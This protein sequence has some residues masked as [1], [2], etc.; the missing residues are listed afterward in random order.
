M[1]EGLVNYPVWHL[2]FPG[3]LLIAAVAI[4]HVFVSH[5]AIGG[6]AYLV[7]TE[8]SAYRRN[9]P[10]LL[11]YV[12]R[13]SKFFA[14]LTVVFGAVSGVGIWF[15]IGLVGPE[16]TSSLI[17]T[18]VWA[19]AIEWVFF[20]VE[21]AAALIYAYQWDRLDRRSHLIVGWI[22]FAAGW[23]S[24][25]VIAGIIG[26]MLTPGRW[27]Q[28]HNFWD[29][30]FNPSYWPSVG[31]RTAMAMAL[32]GMFGLV[33][34]LRRT[35]ARERLVRR[36]G[37]WLILGLALLWPF[38]WWYERRLPNFSHDYLGGLIPAVRHAAHTAI[39]VTIFAIVLAWLFAVWKPRWMNAGVTALL[40]V[41][42]LVIM[43]SGEYVREVSRKPY[44][45]NGYIYANDVRVADVKQIS[46]R[47]V[48][49]VSPWV[50]AA[51]T[52]QLRHGRE[53]FVTECAA[54][55][56]V[57]GYREIRSRVRGWDPVFAR[58]MLP[59]LQLTRGTMPLFAGN[60]NDRT[61]LG[62][63]L[64]SVAAPQ[65]PVSDSELGRRTF[66]TR[67]ALCHTVG[68]KRRPLEFAGMEA[69][70]V[71]ELIGGLSDISPNMPPFTGT[72]AERRALAVYLIQGPQKPR[73]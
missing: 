29:G 59:H 17:H 34:A 73:K 24:L 38:G 72:D 51:G 39:V 70:A 44:T 36:A 64:A 56:S 57:G 1:G 69:D 7:L 48:G 6:G 19:W 62:L 31:I 14:L 68:G 11:A 23:A 66:E 35:P 5:F 65:L 53:L 2:G 20:F 49:A 21:I 41:C 58:E 45:I 37:V 47:G 52:D 28:T 46:E 4:L 26:Y 42:G 32:A 61:A 54:C 3:G 33:T 13:H 15:T 40:L 67:C 25:A 30:F 55:H 9:D 43:G 12:R 50:A 22:Y 27:L 16:A 63:Y 71:Q 10:D 8:W 18:F 60:E